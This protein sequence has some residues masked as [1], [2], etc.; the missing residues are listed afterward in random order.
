MRGVAVLFRND[1]PGAAL[2][3]R[4]V[5]GEV[6]KNAGWGL[7]AV[8]GMGL[9]LFAGGLL[10]LFGACGETAITLLIGVG[11]AAMV[12]TAYRAGLPKRAD[13]AAIPW[14]MRPAIAVVAFLNAG[15]ICWQGNVNEAD[16]LPAYY[17]I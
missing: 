9:Y 6:A 1:R 7:H 15:G 14:G 5:G 3:A 17:N 4:A 2:S 12:W 10:T 8:W 16:D 11:L 13:L